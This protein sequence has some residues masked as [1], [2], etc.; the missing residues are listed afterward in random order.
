MFSRLSAAAAAALFTS[1]YAH[2]IMVTPTPFNNA[3]IDNS[4][5]SSSGSNFPCKYDGTANFYNSAGITN[6]MAIGETQ[7]L[8]FRGSA[9]HG[10][11]SCQLAITKDKAPTPSTSWEV[12]LSIEGGCPSTTGNGPSTYD[13]KIP[14]SVAPGEYVFA[15]T[16]ISKLAGQPEYYMNCAPITVT[17]GSKKRDELSIAK[18]D[19]LPQLFVANLQS[20]NS[21]KTTPGTDPVYPDPG[22]NVSKPGATPN[23][24]QITQTGC[25]PKG[26][27]DNPSS[28]GGSGGQSS[29]AS[30][31]SPS[32][33]TAQAPPP[34]NPTTP[35][36]TAGSSSATAAS[37]LATSSSSVIATPISIP[38]T[39]PAATPV[40]T[41]PSSAPTGTGSTSPT[42]GSGSGSG[43]GSAGALS[44]PCTSEGMWN[45]IGG[46]SFQRCASGM[47]SAVTPMA[48]GTSCT[49]GQSANLAIA[50]R[51]LHIRF[52][53]EHLERRKDSWMKN[54]NV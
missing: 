37:T 19:T 22:P 15:W 12:I 23:Y 6:N 27:S 35:V 38:T 26:V 25:V 33:S 31:S 14:D 51:D 3:T 8:S 20:I 49:P 30:G 34:P 9:V 24:A 17:G 46:T 32:P 44:G 7:T 16:W 11:G 42:G 36:V 54:I 10:G 29:A 53:R 43:S 18:R 40:S 13:Y 47:W 39:F 1:A 52:G 2:M 41:A 50:K 5:L 28:P 21:C 48:G 45:C 4:P